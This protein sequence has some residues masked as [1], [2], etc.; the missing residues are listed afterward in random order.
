MSKQSGL[1][2]KIASGD[3][4]RAVAKDA[5]IEKPHVV[6]RECGA[7]RVVDGGHCLANGW[8]ECCGCTMHLE[9]L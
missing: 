7:E 3:F 2:F 1:L 9:K 4:H 5:G 8:P 6:C